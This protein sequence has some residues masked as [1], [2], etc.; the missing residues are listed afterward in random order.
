MADTPNIP[1]P[2][3]PRELPI[4]DNLVK[5]RDDLTT[6]K[7]DRKNYVKSSDVLPLYDRVVDQVK[8][9]NDIRA[10]KPQEQNRG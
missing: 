5:I 1:P 7:Q 8:L 4:L 10:D 2:I 6:L 9:L 3:D